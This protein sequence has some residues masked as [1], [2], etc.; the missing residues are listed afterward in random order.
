MTDWRLSIANTQYNTKQMSK[1]D[2]PNLMSADEAVK[3]IK[4]A[5]TYIYRAVHQYPRLWWRL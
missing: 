2:I 1:H 4:A 5:T 3:L